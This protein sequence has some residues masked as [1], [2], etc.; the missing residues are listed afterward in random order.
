MLYI[1]KPL[2]DHA[3]L[4]AIACVNRLFEGKDFGYII[5]YRGVL[6]E[7]NAAME[8]YNALEGFDA[9]DL[10]GALTDISTES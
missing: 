10:V 9:E 4:Q 7:L 3:I 2:Q 6:G 5:D 1:D 8:T